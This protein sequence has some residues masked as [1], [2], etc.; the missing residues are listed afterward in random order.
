MFTFS[1]DL[2]D[3]LTLGFYIVSIAYVIFTVVLYYHWMEYAMDERVRTLSLTI[4]FFIS[5]PLLA[6]M[7]AMIFIV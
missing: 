3:L 4:Y 7:G 1:G 5:L 6:L 2:A